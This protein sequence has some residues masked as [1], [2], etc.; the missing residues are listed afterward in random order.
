M[1]I[2]ENFNAENLIT[3]MQALTRNTP[4]KIFLI[5]DNLRVHHS[6]LVKAWLEEDKGKRQF[7]HTYSA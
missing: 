1:I 3:F 7:Q 6:R 2:D 4:K 5:L